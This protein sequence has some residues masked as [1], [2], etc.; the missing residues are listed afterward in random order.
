MIIASK[1]SVLSTEYCNLVSSLLALANV[2]N[3]SIDLLW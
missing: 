3:V 2:A 1:I